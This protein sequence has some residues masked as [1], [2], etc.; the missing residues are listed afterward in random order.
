MSRS[1]SLVRV[2][3]S[4]TTDDRDNFRNKSWKLLKTCG[5]ASRISCWELVLAGDDST[6]HGIAVFSHIACTY[7][8]PF[9]RAAILFKCSKHEILW[10]AVLVHVLFAN[11]DD[12][13]YIIF[14][15]VLWKRLPPIP[16][17]IPRHNR[18]NK[19]KSKIKI[20]GYYLVSVVSRKKYFFAQEKKSTLYWVKLIFN[21]MYH[22]NCIE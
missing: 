21:L 19:S 17:V 1:T 22:Y 12:E 7:T 15:M 13:I 11:L 14:A 3:K 4:D 18:K 9:Q 16:W 5:Y 20:Y 10:L 2:K 6:L 8:W